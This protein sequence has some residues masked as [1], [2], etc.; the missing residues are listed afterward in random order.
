MDRHEEVRF[1]SIG[2]L[3]PVFQL[4]ELVPF[5]CHEN[6][7]SRLLAQEIAQFQRDL[8]RNV[9]F[10]RPTLP[11]CPRVFPTVSWIDHDG[12]KGLGSRLKRL[13]GSGEWRRKIR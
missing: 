10:F 4:D 1:L 11:T 6:T 9:F 2:K 13:L 7:D 5:T 8:Q 3:C 12:L